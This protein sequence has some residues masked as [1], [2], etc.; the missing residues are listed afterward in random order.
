[1]GKFVKFWVLENASLECADLIGG[2]TRSQRV[3]AKGAERDGE[4]TENARK[5]QEIG[6]HNVLQK[7]PVGLF[8]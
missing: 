3:R 8:S 1:M 4:R 2:H 5:F 7:V 6:F